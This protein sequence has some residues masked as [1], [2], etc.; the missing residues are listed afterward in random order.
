MNPLERAVAV[1]AEA[2]SQHML[3]PEDPGAYQAWVAAA[4]AKR[5]ALK[6]DRGARVLSDPAS[7]VLFMVVCSALATL[8]LGSIVALGWQTAARW[9]GGG[10]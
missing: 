7:N 4:Q 8:A 9:W 3:R 2:W 10:P 5:A 1:E 6:A